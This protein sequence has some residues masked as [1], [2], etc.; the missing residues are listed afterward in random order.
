MGKCLRIFCH[1]IWNWNK[2]EL[3]K[4]KNIGRFKSSYV[5]IHIIYLLVFAY[6]SN[7]PHAFFQVASFYRIWQVS[8]FHETLLQLTDLLYPIDIFPLCS[9]TFLSLK[10]IYSTNIIYL[11]LRS[12][13]LVKQNY[14]NECAISN[15]FYAVTLNSLLCMRK[16][17]T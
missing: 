10:R 15:I 5:F 7:T 9:P 4:K 1:R 12:H 3:P 13:A 16:V 17:D 11:I 14:F 8:V 6:F 2:K